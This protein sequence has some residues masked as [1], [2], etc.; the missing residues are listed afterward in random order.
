M[1]ALLFYAAGG[2]RHPRAVAEKA[3]KTREP[4]QHQTGCSHIKS[5]SALF[6]RR[7]VMKSRA[8]IDTV[9]GLCFYQ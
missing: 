3:A 9:T 1:A 4:A 6:R 2:F 8:L 5:G 7:A